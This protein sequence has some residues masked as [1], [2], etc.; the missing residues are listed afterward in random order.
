[1]E[2][3]GYIVLLLLA[4]A[5]VLLLHHR[6]HHRKGGPDELEGMDAWFQ[7]SDVCNF[8]SC[9]HEMWIIG[10]VFTAGIVSACA[11]ATGHF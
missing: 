1:M 6:Y 11:L 3:A 7:V 10:L 4:A 5:L 2:A 9:S 8:H